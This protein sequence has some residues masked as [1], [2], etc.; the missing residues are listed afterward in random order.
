M[1]VAMSPT[2]EAA[3]TEAMRAAPLAAASSH[4]A[5]EC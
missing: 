2:L 4:A 1:I 5:G 3:E